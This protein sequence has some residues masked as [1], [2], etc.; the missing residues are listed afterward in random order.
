MS[1]PGFDADASLYGRTTNRTRTS[2]RAPFSGSQAGVVIP[3]R[4]YC[5][6]CPGILDRCDQNGWRPAGLCNMCY[7]G[8]CY[9]HPFPV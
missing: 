4:P 7:Y 1:I 8:N 9:T 5:G 6:N 3:A 2:P